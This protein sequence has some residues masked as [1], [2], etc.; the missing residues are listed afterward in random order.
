MV[1]H[2]MA[3]PITEDDGDA[4]VTRLLHQLSIFAPRRHTGCQRLSAPARDTAQQDRT[5]R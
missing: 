2:G 4:V 3:G 5:P 1:E